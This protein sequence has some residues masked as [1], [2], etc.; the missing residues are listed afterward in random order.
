M[1]H[2]E[3]S[4]TQMGISL[5]GVKLLPGTFPL[6]T[7]PAVESGRVAGGGSR[8]RITSVH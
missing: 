2:C 5:Q 8:E 7:L 3:L 1:K 6:T 4:E